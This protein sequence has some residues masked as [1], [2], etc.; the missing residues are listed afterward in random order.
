MTNGPKGVQVPPRQGRE[1]VLHLPYFLP[2]LGYFS[3]LAHCDVFVVLDA[4]HF[5]KRHYLD[6]ET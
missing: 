1:G 2:W 5:T 6:R 4:V 3:K